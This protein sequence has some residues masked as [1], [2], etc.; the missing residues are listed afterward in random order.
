MIDV[1]LNSSTFAFFPPIVTFGFFVPKNVPVRVTSVL[2]SGVAGSTP[3]STGSTM[4]NGSGA[5]IGSPPFGWTT[6]EYV[7][8]A[9]F[10]T[11]ATIWVSDNVTTPSLNGRGPVF[12]LS[13]GTI[14]TFGFASPKPWPV[15]VICVPIVASPGS[16]VVMD[17]AHVAATTPAS[18]AAPASTHRRMCRMV[19]P[20]GCRTAA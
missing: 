17:C 4:W 1:S 13:R 12:P 16:T 2:R 10:F 5:V 19:A 8:S 15:M 9:A 7:P 11:A 3:S 18:T 6:T 20:S 14:D